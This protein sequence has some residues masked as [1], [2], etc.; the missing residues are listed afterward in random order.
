MEIRRPATSGAMH[1]G[2]QNI[3]RSDEMTAADEVVGKM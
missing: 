3:E 2:T 1:L